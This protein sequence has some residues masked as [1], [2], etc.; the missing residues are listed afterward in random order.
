KEV[1]GLGYN[2]L[3]SGKEVV[4]SFWEDRDLR[5]PYM[6]HAETNC[7]SLCKKGEVDLLA[8]TLLP[9]ASCA[10]M[11]A[12]YRIPEVV[13]SEV[14]NRDKKAIDIFNFYGIKLTQLC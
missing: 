8:V 3:A 9:C 12:S 7:L 1:L 4:D 6:I 10:T 2:G 11:I 14:Y 13:Y 5:R